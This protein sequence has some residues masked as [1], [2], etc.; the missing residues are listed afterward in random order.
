MRILAGVIVVA[1]SAALLGSGACSG[2]GSSGTGGAFAAKLTTEELMD[3][4]AC[5]RCH[6]EHVRAW[7]GSMHAYAAEDPVFVAMNARGQ[8]ETNGALGDFCVKC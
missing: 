5:V 1:A 4:Q 8:R 7:S 6:E 3:P 2:G